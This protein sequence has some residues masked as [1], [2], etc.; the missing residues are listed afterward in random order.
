V[1]AV[2]AGQLWAALDGRIWMAEEDVLEYIRVKSITIEKVYRYVYE[3]ETEVGVRIKV[4]FVFTVLL[5]VCL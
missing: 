5:F 4:S 3:G 2:S 1:L